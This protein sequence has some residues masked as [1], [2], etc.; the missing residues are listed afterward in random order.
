MVNPDSIGNLP[1]EKADQ[2][3]LN[4]KHPV[5]ATATQDNKIYINYS[6]CAKDFLASV[7]G[8]LSFSIKGELMSVKIARSFLLLLV[9]LPIQYV[10]TGCGPLNPESV[11]TTGTKDTL[12]SCGRAFL[13]DGILG[14]S[15][16]DSVKHEYKI[17]WSKP[18]TSH[19]LSK[20]LDV[21]TY[22]SDEPR[23]RL[24]KD[25]SGHP[26]L[27]TDSSCI[28]EDSLDVLKEAYFEILLTE[29]CEE[30]NPK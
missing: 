29:I 8:I 23:R 28:I 2:Y 19:N 26:V 10:S 17:L 6:G 16:L 13:V 7:S 15:F 11:D 12:I 4:F 1:T 9:L 21:F 14:P 27:W 25:L 30:L 18:K 5:F 20:H 3:N 22:T 24:M